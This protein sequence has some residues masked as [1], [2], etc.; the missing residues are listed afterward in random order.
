M[1]EVV[2]VFHHNDFILFQHGHEGVLEFAV[3]RFPF[4]KLAFIGSREERSGKPRMKSKLPGSSTER[5]GPNIFISVP[6]CAGT[7]YR[8]CCWQN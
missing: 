3:P 4:A 1:N 5:N 8:R 2:S 6:L 7:G